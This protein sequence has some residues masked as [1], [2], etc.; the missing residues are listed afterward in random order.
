MKCLLWAKPYMQKLTKLSP[1]SP[2][3]LSIDGGRQRGR[4]I[5][6]EVLKTERATDKQGRRGDGCP[7]TLPRFFFACA[8]PQHCIRVLLLKVWSRSISLLW[9]LARN[10]TSWDPPQT[11]WTRICILIRSRGDS[12]ASQSLRSAEVRCRVF[13]LLGQKPFSPS[14]PLVPTPSCS[15]FLEAV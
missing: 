15:V 5:Q 9:K 11:Y 13:K 10:A 3:A 2:S 6:N 12:Y 14:G 4:E 7:N 1:C 8:L